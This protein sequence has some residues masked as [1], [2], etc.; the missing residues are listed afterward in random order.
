LKEKNTMN[1]YKALLQERADLVVEAKKLFAAAE[2]DSRDLTEQEKLRDDAIATRLETIAGELQ[3]E[4]RRREWE[5]TVEAVPAANQQP[6]RFTEMRDRAA[7]RPF[8]SLGEQLLAVHH[9]ARNPGNVDPRLLA[10]TGAGESG[11]SGEG[12]L[13]Q[14]EFTTEALG[15]MYSDGEIMSRVKQ[16]KVGANAN[17]IKINV[18]KETS[19]ANGSRW[20]G[21]R[22]YWLNEGGSLTGTK[23]SYRRFSLDLEK[24]GGL[25][26]PTDELLQDVVGLEDEVSDSFA[27]EVTFSSED[28]VYNG[29]GAGK[30]QGLMNAPAKI[31]VA[32]ET[33]QAAATIVEANLLKMWS[34]MWAPSR[35]NAVWL[36]N[37]DIEPQ[38]D[39]IARPVGTGAVPSQHVRYSPDGQILQIKG[40]PVIFVEYAATLGTEG[41]IMLTDLNEYRW[42]DKNGVQTASSIHVYFSTDE[43]A[44]RFIYRCNGAPFWESVLTPYKGTTTLSPIVTLATRS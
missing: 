24:L 15:R 4:E 11:T 40:R 36:A 18:L 8:A 44:F 2:A 6:P 31:A 3:R 12:F 9:A 35:K 29:D 16:R 27:K 33:G 7:E 42:I 28:A 17:G 21:I 10:L 38:L 32:K 14:Q 13:V 23:P 26:I 1:R 37:Q 22:M 30:P 39:V 20:G 34:R 43:M 41:D 25:Y 19:R 5:R